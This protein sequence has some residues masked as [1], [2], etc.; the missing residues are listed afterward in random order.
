MRWERGYTLIETLIAIAITGFLSTVVG[1]AVNQIVTVPERGDD[2]VDAL[3]A[4][5]NAAHWVALDGQMAK[6]AVGGGSLTLTLPNTSVISYTLYGT[7]LH[8]IYGSSNRTIAED[9][10]S[11]NFTVQG[12]IINMSITAAPGSRWSIS[13]NQTYQIYMRPTG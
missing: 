10:S 1:L 9:I 2:Q 3:H 6:S 7:N 12:R 13:E 8:R 11:V 4:V 5:Q